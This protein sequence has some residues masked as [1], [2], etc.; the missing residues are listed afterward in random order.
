MWEG[1][2]L[3]AAREVEVKPIKGKG[4]GRAPKKGEVW[5]FSCS[6]PVMIITCVHF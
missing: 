2:I 6:G 5:V 3:N 4:M 1:N